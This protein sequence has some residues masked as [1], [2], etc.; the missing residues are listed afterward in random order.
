MHKHVRRLGH[1]HV[2][3]ESLATVRAFEFIDG[4]AL[5][6]LGSRTLDHQLVYHADDTCQAS[7]AGQDRAESR[8]A[9]AAGRSTRAAQRQLE[10]RLKISL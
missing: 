5:F 6:L 2:D 10:P 1:R 7:Q 3:F 4:H 8:Q 9:A